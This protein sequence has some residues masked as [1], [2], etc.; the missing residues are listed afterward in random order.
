MDDEQEF[1]WSEDWDA[2][3]DIG[4]VAASLAVIHTTLAKR[5]PQYS[6][7]AMILNAYYQAFADEE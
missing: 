6:A 1:P 4:N 5:Y 7:A 3:Q 2:Q